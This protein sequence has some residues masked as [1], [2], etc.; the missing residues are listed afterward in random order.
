MTAPEGHWEIVPQ[1]L[2]STANPRCDLCGKMIVGRL[3]RVQRKKLLLCFCDRRC[4]FTWLDYWLP[5][6]GSTE[7]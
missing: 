4:Q 1:A 3:W 5:R 2:Y 6:Y 7:S